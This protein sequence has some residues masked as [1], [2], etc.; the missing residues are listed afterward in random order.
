LNKNIE[1]HCM[2]LELNSNV[3]DFNPNIIEF[4]FDLIEL[5]FLNWIQKHW[6][7]FKYIEIGFEFNSIQ[8]QIDV[9]SIENFLVISIVH[10]YI[11]EKKIVL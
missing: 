10:D 11:L 9:E 2:Q 4:I 8:M 1:W 6:F 5:K 7:E 3:F